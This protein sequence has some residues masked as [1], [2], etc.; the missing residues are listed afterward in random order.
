MLNSNLPKSNFAAA[1]TVFGLLF[2]A[3][4][5]LAQEPA[6]GAASP[7]PPSR[8]SFNR[9]ESGFVRLDTTTGT[10]TYCSVHS[11]VGW[12]CEAVPEDRAALEKEIARL[13]DQV[14]SLKD[15]VGG[16]KQELANLREPPPP[17]P[18]ADLSP[19]GKSDDAAKL[20]EDMARARAALENAWRRLVDMIVNFQKDI[21]PKG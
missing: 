2:S 16:L 18:P 1:V 5:S 21:M 15:Q 14:G 4:Q 7:Q 11:S 20:R 3:A 19:P 8:F 6:P 9:V 12:A 10:V 13:Q 17:R